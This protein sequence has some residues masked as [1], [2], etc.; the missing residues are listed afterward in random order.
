MSKVWNEK[1]HIGCSIAQLKK[2]GFCVYRNK[3]FFGGKKG[4]LLFFD[5]RIV[6]NNLNKEDFYEKEIFIYWSANCGNPCNHFIYFRQ[7]P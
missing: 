7:I 4:K 1:E 3:G 5:D 2:L 6:C